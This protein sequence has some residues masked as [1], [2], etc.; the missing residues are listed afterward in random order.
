M[1]LSQK[2]Y[3]SMVY[4][5]LQ[6][7]LT[8]NNSL[9]F[10][11]QK[12][13]PK[14]YL[15]LGINYNK[16][17]SELNNILKSFNLK[18]ACCLQAE[19]PND[20]NMYRINVLVKPPKGYVPLSTDLGNVYK[21]IGM[22]ERPISIPKKQCDKLGKGFK[23]PTDISCQNFYTVY[24]KNMLEK[25]KKVN[26]GVLD[27][28]AFVTFRPE[29]AC[30]AP[31]PQHM[32]D[33]GV[34]AAPMCFLPG[35]EP[36]QGVFLDPVS[37]NPKSACNL[38]LCQANIDMDKFTA[39]RDIGIQNKIEQQCGPGTGTKKVGQGDMSANL[40]NPL[41]G[42]VAIPNSISNKL[43]ATTIGKKINK[44]NKNGTTLLTYSSF[45]SSSC[46]CILIIILIII[47]LVMSSGSDSDSE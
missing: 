45:I 15:P 3:D 35:C 16:S 46:C 36:S 25:F 26:G 37:A 32:I 42:L 18:R 30:F 21:T 24:C 47:A 33:A 17:L 40:N 6:N 1:S 23:N 10:F 38:T 41:A 28:N 22:I 39:G 12:L 13:Q 19:D 4:A 27:N 31:M 8:D 14:G 7:S 2:E 44:I 5:N 11:N 43:A 34:N 20:P 29:C 9:K